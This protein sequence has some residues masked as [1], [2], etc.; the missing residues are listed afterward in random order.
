MGDLSQAVAVSLL[1][2]K[3]LLQLCQGPFL[4]Y[5]SMSPRFHVGWAPW[6]QSLARMEEW[7][8]MGA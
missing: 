8:G 7:D 3:G 5:G 4:L 2:K 1:A 6:G